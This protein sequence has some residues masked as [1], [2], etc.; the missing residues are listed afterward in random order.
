MRFS[1][2][3]GVAA[4]VLALS[5]AAAFA[6][7]QPGTPNQPTWTNEYNP[8]LKPPAFG[9]DSLGGANANKS[10]TGKYSQGSAQSLTPSSGMAQ[11]QQSG[12]AAAKPKS[13]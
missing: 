7:G 8:N 4:T 12:D 13:Q 10:N 3:S 1:I 11:Y 5:A 6:Q 2:I 9:Q